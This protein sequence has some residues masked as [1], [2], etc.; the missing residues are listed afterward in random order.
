MSMQKT[1]TC[2][3][4]GEG[5]ENPANS[6]GLFFTDYRNFTLGGYG[7]TNGKH[8]CYEC[9]RQLRKALNDKEIIELLGED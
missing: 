5:I 2:N 1:Y 9:A 4:C 8:I 6:F 3:V 7:C